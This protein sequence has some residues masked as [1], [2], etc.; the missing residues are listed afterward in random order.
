M[1]QKKVLIASDHAGFA[2]KAEL[3]NVLTDWSWVDLGPSNASSVDYPDF[4]EKLAHAIVEGVA[5][6]GILICGSGIG[7]SVA[8]N[9]VRGIRA[10]LVDNPVSARLSRLHNDANVLC[11]GARFLAA[12][13]AVEITKTFLT[14]SFSDDPKHQRRVDKIQSLERLSSPLKK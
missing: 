9:K 4:A 11:L 6:Q 13:Y 7:M 14:S 1:E 10:A 8:A 12:P 5:P 3:Q 2:L